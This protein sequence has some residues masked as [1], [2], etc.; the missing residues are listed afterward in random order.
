[1]TLY[2]IKRWVKHNPDPLGKEGMVNGYTFLEYSICFICFICF[3]NKI[4][5]DYQKKSQNMYL[6]YFTTEETKDWQDYKRF[7][8][9]N[10]IP[11]EHCLNQRQVHFPLS[12]PQQLSS[13]LSTNNSNTK[14][15]VIGMKIKANTR[16][17]VS[18]LQEAFFSRTLSGCEKQC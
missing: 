7:L 14:H 8:T 4:S 2:E 15:N 10:W 6:P 17:C 16:C 13:L 1:M 5:Y 18:A 3:T 12:W 9:S 11:A